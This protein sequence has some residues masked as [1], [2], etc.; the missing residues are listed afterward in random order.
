MNI[1]DC[2]SQIVALT[3]QNIA[4]LTALNDSFYTK[5]DHI[6]VD[7]NGTTFAIPSFLSLENKIDILQQDMENILNAPKTGEC[8][9]YFDGTTQR[10]ELG[11]YST[12]P[13]H[14]D[15][16][17]VNTFKVEANN[18]FKDFM[19]PNPSIRLD[20]TSIPN[21]IK[22]VNVKKVAIL[23]DDLRSLVCQLTSIASGQASTSIPYAD[24]YRI[25][26]NYQ[27]DVDYVEYDT[28]KRLPTRKGNAYGV[29]N[30][31]SI[32]DNYQDTNLDEFY[33]LVL[34]SDL[35]YT[36]NNGTIMRD[37]VPGDYLVTNDDKVEMV[38]EEVHQ[39][40]RT[41]K[42]RIMYGAYAN[43][44]DQSS[45][46]PD[47]YKLKFYKA[48]NWNLNKYIDEP[49]EEDKYVC[50]FVAPINDTTNVQ[51]PWG[52]GL[53]LNVDNLMMTDGSTSF[54]SYYDKYV[55]NVGDA[56]YAITHMMTD[57]AQ[58]EK[59]TSSDF[60]TIRSY[61]PSVGDGLIVTQI[62]KH[63]NDSTSVKNIRRLY[64]Q[65]TDLKNQLDTI[66]DSIDNINEILSSLSF[67]DTTNTRS[68]YETQL[69]EYNRK[70][71]E[72]LAS[73]SSIINEISVNASD[74]EVPIENAK[75]HI[76][77]FIDVDDFEPT[78]GQYGNLARVIGLDVEYRYRNKN[79]FVGNAETIND[80]YIYSDW[81][82]MDN[83]RRKIT[84]SYQGNSY[85]YE[86]EPLNM[87]KNEIS[88]NQ[89][90][91][92]ITQGET[93]DIRV[94]YIY[95]LGYPFIETTSSWSDI[96][97][98]EFP[99]EYT[100]N[101][102]IL[103]IISENNDDIKKNQYLG[104]M[105]QYGLIEH[106][107]DSIQ[108][109]T[110]KYFHKPEHIASGFYT[111]ERRIIPLKDKLEDI[112]DVIGELQTEVYGALSDNLLVTLNDGNN[113]V[114]IKPNIINTFRT[115]SYRN[116]NTIFE[117]DNNHVTP[118]SNQDLEFKYSQLTLS[119]YN[120]GDYPM[121]LH[122]IF[123]GDSA[124]DLRSDTATSKYNTDNYVIPTTNNSTTTQG[125]YM[126][127][128]DSN[129]VRPQSLNQFIYFRTQVDGA[130]P[131]YS[132]SA[133]DATDN[134]DL[135]SNVKVSKNPQPLTK[136]I[137]LSNRGLDIP[138]STT[139]PFNINNKDRSAFLFPYPGEVSAICASNTD[140][141]IVLRPG[142]RIT[143][144]LSFY[145]WFNSASNL[146]HLSV[147]RSIA[148]DIRTSLFA[149]P[150]CYKLNVVANR[151]DSTE[152][153]VKTELDASNVSSYTINNLTDQVRSLNN[154]IKGNNLTSR[155][156]HNKTPHKSRR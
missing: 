26:Y 34:D 58:I 87:D 36:I 130:D 80:S 147:T 38:I 9:T 150:V 44:Q 135:Q 65:K 93:V 60:N 79:M 85:V 152:Y 125:I 53:F 49:L 7:V 33:E 154:S 32:S 131:L 81:N 136:D 118:S 35:V 5:R 13:V 8:F 3:Q 71:R 22:H 15:L 16:P 91:I 145:Y 48:A 63:L 100:T 132:L 20:I 126:L 117:V 39:A 99:P 107:G 76:R 37:I 98:V 68:V 42:V 29:Y 61:K 112:V 6:A 127:F 114:Q 57:G 70:R 133:T 28:I 155:P 64:A 75:Y 138:G 41:I 12:T 47:L 86:I 55:N 140:S 14:V 84:P 52:T 94:R 111:D 56:L 113:V 66:Q 92:P 137:V 78:S 45:A 156:L 24:L 115:Q 46:N 141:F 50:V 129:P 104:L 124:I 134:D 69:D 97:N 43:L 119:L 144:P 27:K 101:V 151:D 143:I 72:T 73:I 54:R 88:F 59:L 77:G 96:L 121:K 30:I 4:I 103:D 102:E 139:P 90:D 105:E 1:N 95:N 2:L 25:L 11:G 89:V 40:A 62:N 106:A 109:Q 10:L 17:I 110:I 21:N 146:K 142:D 153:T 116:N 67:D 120:S 23:N 51:A 108:D 31:V 83:I 122:S 19:T 74:S 148:F 149:D 18:I 128:D 82:R 123:P